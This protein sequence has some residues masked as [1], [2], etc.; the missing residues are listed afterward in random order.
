M[1][2]ILIEF[3]KQLSQGIPGTINFFIEAITNGKDKKEEIKV[4]AAFNRMLDNNI[5]GSKLYMLWND[6]L[7]RDTDRA[8]YIFLHDTIDSILKHINYENGRGIPY[9]ENEPTLYIKSD[10]E[11]WIFTFLNDGSKMAGKCVKVKGTYDKTRTKMI[12]HYGTHWGFQYSEKEWEEKW[13]DPN[14]VYPME[15]I[16]EIID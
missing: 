1:D 6:C 3:A 8:I 15:D 4:I 13:N 16:I 2:D 5:T 12:D 10:D 14:R 9:S 11:Y 7:N